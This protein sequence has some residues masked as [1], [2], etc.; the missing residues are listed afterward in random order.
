MHLGAGAGWRKTGRRVLHIAACL[1]LI[2]AVWPAPSHAQS[3]STGAAIAGSALGLAS[4]AT[5][6]FVGSLVP[7]TQTKPGPTCVRWSSVGGGVLG[8]TGGAM[9]GASDSDRLGDMAVGAGIGFAA[10]AAAGLVLQ[11]EAERFGWADV[12]AVGLLGGA[13]GSAPLGSAIGFAG[14]SALGLLAWSLWDGFEIP[15]LIGAAAIG[16]AIGG[17]AEWLATGIDASS[18]PAAGLQVSLPAPAGF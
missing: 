9:I 18:G 7:C 16:M 14:G 6:A 12:A 17:L 8:L 3:G 2:G 5:L 10:G 4:G 15:D 13:I 1:C 11:S